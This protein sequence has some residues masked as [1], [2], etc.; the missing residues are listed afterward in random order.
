MLLFIHVFFISDHI[1]MLHTSSIV[2]K[3]NNSKFTIFSEQNR[4]ASV[5]RSFGC[6]AGLV[7]DKIKIHDIRRT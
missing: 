6:Y 5:S 2:V 4:N 1:V 7:V 3:F